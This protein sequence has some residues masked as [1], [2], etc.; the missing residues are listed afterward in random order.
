MDPVYLVAADYPRILSLWQRAGL[1]IRPH[2]RDSQEAFAGQLASGIQ[3]ALGLEEDGVL[4]GVIVVTH[5]SRKGWLNRLAIDPSYRRRG[6][7][8]R[9]I[10][11]AE[12]HLRKQGIQ[13]IAALIEDWNEA[14]LVLFTKA[15]Y[16]DFSGIHYL[17]KRPGPEA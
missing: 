3:V 12:E 8:L 15:G 4:V 13:V 2:G 16:V 5:D 17:S 14:S 1:S 11:A 7:G 10:R 9:L 6:W